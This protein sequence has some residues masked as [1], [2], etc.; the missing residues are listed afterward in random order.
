MAATYTSKEQCNNERPV[1]ALGILP[2]EQGH[3][4]PDGTVH[5]F[6]I[7]LRMVEEFRMR[8][9][10]N[11]DADPLRAVAKVYEE[12]LTRIKEHLG[13]G[14]DEFTAACPTLLALSPSMYR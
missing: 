14:R 8:V 4:V 1:A 9:K 6:Q 10:E 3:S 11:I 2:P 7:G 12:E 13:E 5:P